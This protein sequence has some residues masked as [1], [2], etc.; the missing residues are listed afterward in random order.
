MAKTAK[1]AVVTLKGRL[2]S[3]NDGKKSYALGKKY[4]VTEAE[5]VRLLASDHF[6]RVGEKQPSAA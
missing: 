2:S 1:K 6:V 5:A 4:E 3:Y